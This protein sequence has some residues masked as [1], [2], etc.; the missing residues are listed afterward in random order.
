MNIFK[1]LSHYVY[2]A[3]WFLRAR[4]LGRR[5]PL[6]TVLFITDKCNLRCKHCSVYGSAGYK[7][8][9]FEDIVADMQY[10]YEQGSRFI[11]LEGGEPTLWKE[12]GRE[13]SEARGERR[14]AK[15]EY[16]TINDLI[17]K[18]LEIGF[19]SVTVT[20]NA[21]QDFSWIRPQSI[22]VSMDGV[23][24]YHDRIRGEGTFARLEE[25]IQKSG[26]KHIC[27][28]MVVNALNYESL[29]AAMEYAKSNPAIEQISINFHTPYP[30]TEYLMLPLEKKAEL[31]DKVLAY[32][33][34]GYPIMNS[35]SGLKLMKRN[36]LGEIKLG[37][38]CFVTNFI[39]TDGSRS[40]C[41]GYGTEQCRVCGF[42]MAGEM[43]SVW[44]FKLD[45]V[46][47]GFKLR[48]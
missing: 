39:Y 25:N 46:L 44:G 32:K 24:E 37:K 22:W 34:K 30:G 18:A 2:L 29:D 21:Q 47:A 19:F 16:Y 26:F 6:Q 12:D 36:A 7:Q 3:Q 10:S 20:T 28:N 33:K 45:T 5:A 42:C 13:I 17:D 11:D 1:T 23:G 41:L 31:I 9:R 4:F 8:R 40:L 43:A 38:E 15:G 14:E 35:R 27:V 48:M